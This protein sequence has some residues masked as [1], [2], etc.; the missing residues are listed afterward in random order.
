MDSVVLY[1]KNGKSFDT[2]VI[3]YFVL[4]DKKYFI[5]SLNE[6]DSNDYVQL[7]AAKI[8]DVDG[9]LTMKNITDETE[10]AAFRNNMEKIVN[11]NRNGVLN[12]DDLDY[13]ELNNMT[14]TE[15]RIFKVK[16]GVAEELGKNKNVVIPEPVVEGPV[17]QTPEVKEE[18]SEPQTLEAASAQ[19][20]GMTIE[21]ILK[22]V[23]SGAK[24]AKEE[25]KVDLNKK[26]KATIDD[27][28]NSA[29]YREIE[30]KPKFITPVIE[31]EPEPV[32]APTIEPV[33]S[34]ATEPK[35]ES[36]TSN[37]VEPKVIDDVISKP[38]DEV[39][40]K[41]KYEQTLINMKSL[42]EENMRLINELVEAKAKIAT[43]KDIL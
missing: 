3:R 28:L 29:S 15:F 11:N 43:I 40:Y 34:T 32:V 33:I 27:L 6:V 36:I 13:K 21:E 9:V 16:T 20:S 42:E 4:N 41:A 1:N 30:P 7:Y 26:N 18:V 12:S 31:T 2:K 10:W 22:Q 17:I 23:S 35:T 14:V 39:D 19:E 8:E 5:F 38:K 24:N 25:S 37:I